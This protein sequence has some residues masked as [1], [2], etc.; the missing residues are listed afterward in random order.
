MTT[1][2]MTSDAWWILTYTR[3]K[4]TTAASTKST[5]P[6]GVRSASRTAAQKL[7]VECPLGADLLCDAATRLDQ[8][9]RTTS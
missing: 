9:A 5:G 7:A 4:E 8:S 1:P 2:P 3:L 6:H